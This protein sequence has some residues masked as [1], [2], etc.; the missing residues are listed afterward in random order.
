MGDDPGLQRE[1]VVPLGLVPL[2]QGVVGWYL[3]LSVWWHGAVLLKVQLITL[4]TGLHNRQMEVTQVT[5]RAIHATQS[6]SISLDKV[7]WP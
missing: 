4:Q 7:H 1:S 3:S 2:A 5:W 6:T